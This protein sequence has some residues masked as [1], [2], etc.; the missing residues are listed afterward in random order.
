MAPLAVDPDAMLLAGTGVSVVGDGIAAD[1]SPSSAGFAS[2]SGRDR[3]PPRRR[4]HDPQS[5]PPRVQGELIT[6]LRRIG[7]R[8]KGVTVPVGSVARHSGPCCADLRAQD[9]V[10]RSPPCGMETR[11][12]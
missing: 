3:C 10:D 6:S 12:S 11:C 4:R 7:E 2:N 1:P 9:A 8:R 5:R